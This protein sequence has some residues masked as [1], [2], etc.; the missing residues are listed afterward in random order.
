MFEIT[1]KILFG[2]FIAVE[3]LGVGIIILMQYEKIKRTRDRVWLGISLLVGGF[4]MKLVLI[5]SEI[6]GTIR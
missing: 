2:L 3:F 5:V 1:F 4:G 6:I